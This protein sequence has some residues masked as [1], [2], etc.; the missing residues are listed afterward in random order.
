MIKLISILFVLFNTSAT[1]AGCVSSPT[2]ATPFIPPS[3]NE[4]VGT[5]KSR[6][7]FYL[8]LD[9]A[10]KSFSFA[11]SAQA[12]EEKLGPYGSF[13]LNGSELHLL[14]SSD[15]EICPDIK[16]RFQ[17]EIVRNGN[18]RLT[19]IDDPCI[20]RVEGVFQGGAGGN[21]FLEF[22]RVQ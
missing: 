10:D 8:I 9:D 14:E 21:R 1:L 22:R 17:A 18:L 3:L 7:N 20:Y 2:M 16:A 12:A 15:S 13:T 6:N 19:I 5:W 11:D 4:I